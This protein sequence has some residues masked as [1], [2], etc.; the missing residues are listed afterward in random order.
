MRQKTEKKNATFLTA[1]GQRVSSDHFQFG[2]IP[3]GILM[4]KCTAPAGHRERR[5]WGAEQFHSGVLRRSNGSRR[6]GCSLTCGRHLMPWNGAVA[7]TQQMDPKG[8]R[9]EIGKKSRERPPS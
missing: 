2:N 9:R 7:G 1:N 8:R 3:L 6:K 5:A 4:S